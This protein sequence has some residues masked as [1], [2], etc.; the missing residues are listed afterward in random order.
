MTELAENNMRREE[1][2]VFGGP[3][4]T[5]RS[6]PKWP[7]ADARTEEMILDV[8]RSE[9]WSI[10]GPYTG[11][12][13]YERRFAAAFA[14]Y[15]GVR[16]CVPTSNG[17][18]ALTTALLALGIGPGDEVLVPGLT[19][20]ACASS[21]FCVGAIPILVDIEPDTLAM[22][23]EQAHAAITDRT[24]AIMLVHPYCRLA[25]IDTFLALSRQFNIPI[26]EDCSLA[27]G[28][29]WKGRRVGS[30]GQIGCFSMQ[31]SKV[32]TSGEGGAAITDDIDLYERLEELRSDGRLFTSSPKNGCLELEDTGGI[33]GQNFSLSEFQAAVLFDRLGSLDGQNA[34]REQCATTLS[35][36]LSTMDGIS[37]LRLQQHATSYTYYRFVVRIEPKLFSGASI[38]AIARAITCELG[39]QVSPLSQPL[40][41]HRLYKPLTSPRLRRTSEN[42]A[43]LDPS[44]F[45]LP[46]ADWA[47]ERHLTLP[48]RMLLSD[49]DG[50]HDIV[51]ALAKVKRLSRDLAAMDQTARTV[52]GKA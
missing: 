4:V 6:W 14:A 12:S 46:V 28:A 29:R 49:E 52:S 32:L 18:A 47:R 11:R 27:H 41:R 3:P 5:S 1:L 16:Y 36:L 10:S 25:D 30:F 8:V 44:R 45:A 26:I 9:R 2:A 40:N 37:G 39:I 24:A 23:I 31:Q 48:H 20:V 51:S 13:C 34:R 7:I 19:W 43:R 38:D 50:I 17:S 42:Y 21:V 22:G 15:N 35:H 33:L